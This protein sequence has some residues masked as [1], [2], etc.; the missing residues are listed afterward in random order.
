MSRI[1]LGKQGR[2]VAAVSA[3]PVTN[4]MGLIL[5]SK[6]AVV[7]PVAVQSMGA[8][9]ITATV[10]GRLDRL[11]SPAFLVCLADTHTVYIR[12]PVTGQRSTHHRSRPAWWPISVLALVAAAQEPRDAIVPASP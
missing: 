12:P 1:L 2:Q 3:L 6:A 5:L 8:T 10:T 7:E 9:A 11:I 4:V